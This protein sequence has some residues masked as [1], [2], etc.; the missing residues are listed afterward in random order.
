MKLLLS[1]LLAM[2]IVPA[3]HAQ[4]NKEKSAGKMAFSSINQVG[5]LTGAAGESATVQ[6]ING[7][8]INKWFT[9]IGAAINYYGMRSIPV[10]ADV[11]KT[12]G[13]KPNSPFV[14]V[15][16]GLNF[17]W[18]TTNQLQQK[19][20]EKSD[21]KGPFY[22]VGLG[23]KLSGKHNRAILISAGYSYKKMRNQSPM[24]SILPW[25]RPVTPNYET[26]TNHFRTIVVKVGVQL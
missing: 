20:Y 4:K 6:T 8:Q 21:I 11:R 5:V 9:G 10:F 13:N 1:C 23:Y 25:P 17:P 22:D 7:V 26:Y 24:Y 12:F 16:A 2:L 14:Y 15:D 19:G 18:E 3:I